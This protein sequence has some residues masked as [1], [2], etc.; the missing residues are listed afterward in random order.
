MDCSGSCVP[1]LMDEALQARN[2]RRML[3]A[4]IAATFVALVVGGLLGPA[5]AL[6]GSGDFCVSCDLNAH[7]AHVGNYRSH[8]YETES[9]NSDG[10]GVG[11]CTGVGEG[12]AYYENIACHGDASGYNEVYCTACNGDID[13]W[14]I[15]ENNSNH[16]YN[17]VF[18]GWEWY[19]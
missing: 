15:V 1:R 18:T 4:L 12:A 13:W 9:W 17:S 3:A 14:S 8:W 16:G 11:S 10:K 2:P 7:T 19:E 5:R 6:A